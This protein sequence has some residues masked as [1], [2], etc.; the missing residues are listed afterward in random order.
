MV[1]ASKS[2][3][4]AAKTIRR[5]AH[6]MSLVGDASPVAE[7]VEV[8]AWPVHATELPVCAVDKTKKSESLQVLFICR[9]SL[10]NAE[11]GHIAVN[12]PVMGPQ[13]HSG[14]P[15]AI[16][17]LRSYLAVGD[18]IALRASSSAFWALVRQT[19]ISIDKVSLGVA[20]ISENSFLPSSERLVAKN[21]GPSRP[22]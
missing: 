11:P 4:L 19:A 9:P 16:R 2:F 3:D 7:D 8:C 13:D 5:T 18:F 12:R 21:S 22:T 10:G 14:Q 20:S 15:V 17:R 6:P 1:R